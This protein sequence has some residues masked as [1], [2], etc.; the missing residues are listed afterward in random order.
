[1]K[2]NQAMLDELIGMMLPCMKLLIF[3]KTNTNDVTHLLRNGCALAPKMVL[4][5]ILDV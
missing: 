3:S 2:L 5:A 1:M 4:P